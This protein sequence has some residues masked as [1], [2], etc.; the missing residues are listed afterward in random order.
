MAEP[1]ASD[2]PDASVDTSVASAAREVEEFLAAGG[3]NQPVQLFALVDTASLLAKQPELEDQL[4]THAAL[5]PVAQEALPDSDLAEALAGIVWPETVHGCALAQ[6][7]IVLPPDAE[8]DLPGAGDSENGEDSDGSAGGGQDDE[9]LRRAA[10]DHPSRTEARLVAAVTRDGT[11]A[12]VM[13][14]RA[15]TGEAETGGGARDRDADNGPDTTRTGEAGGGQF[16]VDE[17]I[18]HPDLAPNL[19]RALEA[20][21]QP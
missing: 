3:W 14:L 18:E 17:V 9:R 1:D 6:E 19:I 10:A 21:L 4:D 16:P 5:T 20:T 15:S 13:R 2:A 12:C 8:G 11:R 7:I